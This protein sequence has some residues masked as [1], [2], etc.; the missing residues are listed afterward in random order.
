MTKGSQIDNFEVSEST[1]AYLKKKEIHNLMEDLAAAVLKEKPSDVEA[2]L[3]ESLGPVKLR[4]QDGWTEEYAG[5]AY[6]YTSPEGVTQMERPSIF[7]D[8]KSFN[9]STQDG[10]KKSW[11]Y[12]DRRVFYKNPDGKS[13]WSAGGSPFES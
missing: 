10:W 4:E 9:L 12:K 8:T 7:R 13:G 2:F 1:N 5:D 3:Q 6:V 11:S